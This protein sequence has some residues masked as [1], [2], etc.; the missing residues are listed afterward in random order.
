MNRYFYNE[1]YLWIDIFKEYNVTITPWVNLLGM[2]V[3]GPTCDFSWG[4]G[5]RLSMKL[6]YPLYHH[7]LKW[8]SWCI[9]CY[10]VQ[11]MFLQQELK[12]FLFFNLA[13]KIQGHRERDE[14]CVLD[15]TIWRTLH[16]PSCLKPRT[17][18]PIL[19]WKF[20]PF[21]VSMTSS[22]FWL[23]FYLSGFFG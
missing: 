11:T 1:Y 5:R 4:I 17:K 19:S 10:W 14:N 6:I 18:H 16:S 22:H 9:I 20:F 21:L 3:K 13:T 7:M 23:P 8:F 12:W 2:K 15:L